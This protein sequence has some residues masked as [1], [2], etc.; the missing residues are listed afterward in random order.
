MLGSTTVRRNSADMQSNEVP[1]LE[2]PR[3]SSRVFV[4]PISLYDVSDAKVAA[5]YIPETCTVRYDEKTGQR[6]IESKAQGLQCGLVPVNAQLAVAPD[7]GVY[8]LIRA[9]SSGKYLVNVQLKDRNTGQI[10]NFSLIEEAGPGDLDDL[11]TPLWKGEEANEFQAG[12]QVENQP[13]RGIKRKGS[14]VLRANNSNVQSFASDP[15]EREFRPGHGPY[16]P[17][18]SSTLTHPSFNQAAIYAGAAR[19][20]RKLAQLMGASWVQQMISS[21]SGKHEI[22]EFPDAISELNAFYSPADEGIRYG[23]SNGKWSLATDGNVQNHERGHHHLDMLAPNLIGMGADAGAIHEGYG[24][25]LQ[26]FISRDPVLSEDVSKAVPS[27][28]LGK[29]LRN[30]LNDKKISTTSSEVHARGEVF[31]GFSWSVAEY[32]H[33]VFTGKAR[34]AD[35]HGEKLDQRAADLSLM[36]LCTFPSYLG[37]RAATRLDFVRAN[38]KA[39]EILKQAGKLDARIDVGAL[40]KFMDAEATRRELNVRKVAS[41]KLPGAQ[42]KPAEPPPTPNPVELPEEEILHGEVKERGEEHKLTNATNTQSAIVH[43]LGHTVL[44]PYSRVSKVGATFQ[45]INGDQVSRFVVFRQIVVNG[46]TYEL[47][48]QDDY[49]TIIAHPDKTFSAQ[50]GRLCD[51]DGKTPEIRIPSK[52]EEGSTRLAPAASGLPSSWDRAILARLKSAVR[53]DLDALVEEDRLE[54]FR[55]GDLQP[56]GAVFEHSH[57]TWHEESYDPVRRRAWS[58]AARARTNFLNQNVKQQIVFIKDKVWA[59]MSAGD[60]TYYAEVKG[61]GSISAPILGISAFCGP[62]NFRATTAN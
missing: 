53:A 56:S 23:I 51:I 34:A 36:L 15:A 2:T 24:D 19:E 45:T 59:T 60:L 43:A 35:P 55:S 5:S 27:I 31:A 42:P 17:H 47:P 26:A 9:E 25:A 38:K 20:L 44:D 1:Q 32:L 57:E 62:L 7:G 46:V 61:D 33:E 21:K 40:Q 11:E 22:T 28:E 18:K 6:F 39:V 16:D 13:L 37:S 12:G 4:A 52:I 10:K 30:A 49:L 29:G 48:V 8:A 3:Y 41:P 14:Y 54:R 58:L 50:L